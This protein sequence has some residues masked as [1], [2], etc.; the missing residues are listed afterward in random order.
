MSLVLKAQ[1]AT[2]DEGTGSEKDADISSEIVLMKRC[3]ESGLRN[4][5]II[6]RISLNECRIDV[7]SFKNS[8]LVSG[9][10]GLGYL[11]IILAAGIWHWNMDSKKYETVVGKQG[12]C[13]CRLGKLRL[14]LRPDKMKLMGWFN[15][16][17]IWAD[18]LSMWAVK[19]V[20]SNVIYGRLW[21]TV[22]LLAS[23]DSYN[24]VSI[25]SSWLYGIEYG[26]EKYGNS[27]LNTG[28]VQA[29]LIAEVRQRYKQGL[30]AD[31]RMRQ[32]SHERG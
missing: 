23:S 15:S 25:K 26:S 11:G 29:D 27:W 6:V 32:Q 19:M 14:G 7:L 1:V 5:S 31:R 2:L 10:V 18:C 21:F 13:A 9:E 4:H 22:F 12:N 3:R 30:Q 17:V 16:L 28:I 8:Q 24:T 20:S